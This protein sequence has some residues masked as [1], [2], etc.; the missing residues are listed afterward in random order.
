V[1]IS[2]GARTNLGVMAWLAG[3]TVGEEMTMSVDG[4]LVCGHCL[5]DI[6]ATA[7]LSGLKSLQIRATDT[8]TGSTRIYFWTPVMVELERR[9]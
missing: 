9:K 5:K 4:R 7:E 2:L 8:Q 3:R 1:G 6:A